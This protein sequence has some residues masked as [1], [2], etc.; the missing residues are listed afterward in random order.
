MHLHLPAWPYGNEA[1][2]WSA[3][4]LPGAIL[5]PAPSP[6]KSSRFGV[7]LFLGSAAPAPVP[8]R[9]PAGADALTHHR[10][11]SLTVFQNRM[12]VR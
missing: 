3:A 11:N 6:P 2:S 8:L 5:A 10:T 4:A 7:L 1:A 9:L 12:L